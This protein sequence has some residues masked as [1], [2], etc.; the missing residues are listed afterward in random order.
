MFDAKPI[1]A[2]AHILYSISYHLAGNSCRHFINF[3]ALFFVILS[4]GNLL[5]FAMLSISAHSLF[6]PS[7]VKGKVSNLFI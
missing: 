1:C 4:S 7:C 5:L 6:F 2:F 3:F